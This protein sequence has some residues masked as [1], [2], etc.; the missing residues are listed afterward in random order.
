MRPRVHISVILATL[1]ALA[2]AW[3]VW[4]QSIASTMKEQLTAWTVEAKALGWTIGTG[5]VAIDGFPFLLRMRLA[6]PA[7]G[8]G[9]GRLWRGPPLSVTLRP[10]AP[11]RASLTMPGQHLLSAGGEPLV[12]QMGTAK[13]DLVLG[14]HGLEALAADFG[15]LTAGGAHLGRAELSLNRLAFAPV[16]FSTPSLSLSLT[17]RDLLPAAEPPP[18]MGRRL[19]VAAV[20]ARLLGWLP[21]AAPKV[22]VEA[23]RRDGGTVEV[24]GLT[25]EWPPL[26]LSG[27]G[28]LALDRDL[29]PLW[30]GSCS[31]RGLGEAIDALTGQGL[32]R[33]K[34]GALAKLVL[35]LLSRPAADGVAELTAPVSVEDRMLHIGPAAL[36]KL[37]ELTWPW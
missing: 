16:T 27:K 20:K 21:A 29:Q 30:A 11:E 37:P 23:W 1:V 8:D 9:A 13:V 25:V 4:W 15:D 10:W 17:L 28:T 19:V 33:A 12:L 34:D 26:R 36:F 2:A 24:D 5:E 31:I 22:S 6:A 3:L 18:P 32:V 7:V 35:G 14:G